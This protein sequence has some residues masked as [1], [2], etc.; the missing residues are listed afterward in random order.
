MEKGRILTGGRICREDRY[1]EPTV[2]DEV[3]PDDPI[4]QQEIFGP[5]LPVL[6]FRKPE[7]VI[8]YINAHEKPLAL[9]YFG[10]P[11][12]ARCI[13]ARTS[14][15]GACVN[16]TVMHIAN[17]HLP[18][19]GV[20]NSGMGRYHGYDSF[21]TFSNRRSVLYATTWWDIPFKYPPYRKLSFLKKMPGFRGL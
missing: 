14:S 18:F 15:G 8:A 13:L 17:L 3:L 5:L 19:G 20:G 4:M 6:E 7:E 2:I 9:Y 10:N 11:Q 12:Q 16:D 1:V 21:L